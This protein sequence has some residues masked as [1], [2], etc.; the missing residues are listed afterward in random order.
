MS[1]LGSYDGFPRFSLLDLG[2]SLLVSN[3]K[4]VTLIA[5]S[6]AKLNTLKDRLNT[7]AAGHSGTL[8]V[9]RFF[10]AG[11]AEGIYF[12]YVDEHEVKRISELSQTLSSLDFI[13]Y[14][15]YRYLKAGR[16]ASL[17]SDHYLLRISLISSSMKVSRMAGLGRTT[18]EDSVRIISNLINFEA[19][20]AGCDE[21]VFIV[22]GFQQSQKN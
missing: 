7:S 1:K 10:E 17:L 16:T 20:S 13:V 8:S 19:K 22:K 11:I 9:E 18:P 5:N 4:V 14:I 3:D 12:N 21:E 6:F 15:N 2:F